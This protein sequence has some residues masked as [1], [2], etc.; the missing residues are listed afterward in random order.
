MYIKSVPLATESGISSIILTPMKI[1]QPYHSLLSSTCP[2]VSL[3]VI[4]HVSSR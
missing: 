4:L 1:V 2:A 3:P